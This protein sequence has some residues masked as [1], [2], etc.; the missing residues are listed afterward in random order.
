[1]YARV[2]RFKGVD[3][4]TIDKVIANIEE[5]DGPPPGVKASGMKLLWDA[6][7]STSVFIGFF[8]NEQ[9]LKDADEIFENMDRGDTPGERVSVDRAEVVIERDA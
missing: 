5:S 8:E 2:V 7:Q 3:R 1:M 6:D 9:D 4:D